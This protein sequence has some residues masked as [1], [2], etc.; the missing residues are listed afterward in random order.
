MKLTPY[1]KLVIAFLTQ[2]TSM[3]Y[4]LCRKHGINESKYTTEV[5]DMAANLLEE[6][7]K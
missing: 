5:M 6:D 1:Q 4:E 3:V 2:I 7:N